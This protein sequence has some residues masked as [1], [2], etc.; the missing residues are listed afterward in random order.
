MPQCNPTCKGWDV[1]DSG[2]RGL[3]IQACD[4]CDRYESD[5]DAFRAALRQLKISPAMARAI[6]NPYD[7]IP[8]GTFKALVRRRIIGWGGEPTQLGAALA[9]GL[10]WYPIKRSICRGVGLRGWTMCCLYAD[11][12]ELL[13]LDV[14]GRTIAATVTEARACYPGEKLHLSASDFWLRSEKWE[15][16]GLI[17]DK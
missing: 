7:P 4:D 11:G 16:L 15:G 14:Q 12:T 10:H 2:T 1:F 8:W 13:D 17:R 9:A 6:V 5:A 3:E